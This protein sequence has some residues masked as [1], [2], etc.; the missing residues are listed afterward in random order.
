VTKADLLRLRTPILYVVGGPG[1]VAHP[2]GLDDFSRIDR[3]PV[4]LADRRDAGHM[5]LFNDPAGRSTEIEIDWLR[6]Q[7]DDDARAG[8]TFIGEDCGLCYAP[9]W[10]VRRKGIR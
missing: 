2:N 7:L 6:W 5:G 8:R 1:D 4:F 9:G 10:T 3:V